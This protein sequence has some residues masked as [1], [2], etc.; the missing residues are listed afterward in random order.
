MLYCTY[1]KICTCFPTSMMFL[2]SGQTSITHLLAMVVYIVIEE[3][4][5]VQLRHTFLKVLVFDNEVQVFVLDIQ[6][7][8]RSSVFLPSAYSTEW[9]VCGPLPAL[10]VSSQKPIHIAVLTYQ[11]IITNCLSFENSKCYVVLNVLAW[12]ESC[13]VL[14]QTSCHDCTAVD[15]WQPL[16]WC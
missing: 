16:L 1:F 15:E 11:W 10:S 3:I 8:V 2:I 13:T 14:F 5:D 12:Y 9:C 4:S 7:H 6:G